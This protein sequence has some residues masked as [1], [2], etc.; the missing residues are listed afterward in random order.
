MAKRLPQSFNRQKIFKKLFK[1]EDGK[2]FHKARFNQHAWN[3]RWAGKEAGTSKWNMTQP[4]PT[5]KIELIFTVDGVKYKE[6]ASRVIWQ[7]FNGNIPEGHFVALE[8]HN[9]MDTRIE[10]LRCVVEHTQQRNKAPR[11]ATSPQ[12]KRPP[13]PKQSNCQGVSY[14]QGSNRWRARIGNSTLGWFTTERE[15]VIVRKQAEITEGY[16]EHH[17]VALV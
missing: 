16:H 6:V 9:T 7:M 10:N 15:A 2:L 3:K 17:G 4:T 14:H 1:Y 13:A 12:S 5:E 11:K 8:N